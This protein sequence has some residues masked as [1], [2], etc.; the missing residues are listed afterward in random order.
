MP[1][2]SAGTSRSRSC[3]SASATGSPR[4]PSSGCWASSLR[5]HRHRRHPTG[6]DLAISAHDCVRA[7]LAAA[8]SADNPA[9]ARAD[10]A[11][12]VRA[13]LTSGEPLPDI[14]DVHAR[15]KAG[16]PIETDITVEAW[17][18]Q[19]LAAKKDLRL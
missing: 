9:S 11:S 16:A 8:D 18:Q 7:L 1:W 2:P 19:W 10:I 4:C 5:R 15:V 17:L 6:R 13:R 14:S 3:L 12:L